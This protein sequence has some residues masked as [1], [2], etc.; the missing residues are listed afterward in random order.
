MY[1]PPADPAG[2]HAGDE[3]PAQDE[4]PADAAGVPVEDSPAEPART[5]EEQ[6]FFDSFRIYVVG[7]TEKWQKKAAEVFPTMHFLGSEKNFDRSAL[8]QADYVIINTNAVSH[9]CTEKAKN[10]APKSASIIMTS[11]NNLHLLQRKLLETIQ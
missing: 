4:P 3:P 9:A 10:A 8:A 11:N 7:G 2:V 5:R 6:E 1:E